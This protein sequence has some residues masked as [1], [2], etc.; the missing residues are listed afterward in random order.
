MERRRHDGERLTLRHGGDPPLWQ[1]AAG[2]GPVEIVSQVEV[3]MVV[4]EPL[5]VLHEDERIPS[6][7]SRQVGV[8]ESQRRLRGGDWISMLS[9]VVVDER[10]VGLVQL[11]LVSI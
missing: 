11:P 1:K 10:H 3:V 9:E 7:A 6:L 5:Y 4:E 2:V 8:E